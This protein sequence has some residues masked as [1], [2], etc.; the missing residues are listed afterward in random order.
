MVSAVQYLTKFK[1]KPVNIFSGTDTPLMYFCLDYGLHRL[2]M[3]ITRVHYDED[4]WSSIDSLYDS[5][6]S[7]IFVVDSAQLMSS[8]DW[9]FEYR[10]NPYLNTY[11]FFLFEDGNMDLKSSENTCFV[12][13]ILSM[14]L[15]RKFLAYLGYSEKDIDLIIQSP[16]KDSLNDILHRHDFDYVCSKYYLGESYSLDDLVTRLAQSIK[17]AEQLY[18]GTRKIWEIG[19]FLGIPIDVVLSLKNLFHENVS[20]QSVTSL[21]TYIHKQIEIIRQVKDLEKYEGCLNYREILKMLV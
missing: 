2:N 14:S 20:R 17:V 4:I 7:Q 16:C 11:L 13:C 3:S 10:K 6:K 18:S 1:I 15:R 12:D 8:I 9:I 5:E 19:S 21:D